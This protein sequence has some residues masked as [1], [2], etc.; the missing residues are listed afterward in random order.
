MVNQGATRS[1]FRDTTGC[2][3]ANDF[4]A[5][6][7]AD[8]GLVE[9]CN[10]GDLEPPEGVFTLDLSQGWSNSNWNLH[11]IERM[12]KLV[13]NLDVASSLVAVEDGYLKALFQGQI[14]RAQQAWQ[15]PRQRE[16]ETEEEARLRTKDSDERRAAQV[17]SRARKQAVSWLGRESL[18][19]DASTEA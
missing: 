11:L 5:Y 9:K 4:R 12:V 8:E 13:R 19:I 15:L 18:Y 10:D 2:D 1:V 16:L 14:K 7:P 3:Q 6:E 17:E